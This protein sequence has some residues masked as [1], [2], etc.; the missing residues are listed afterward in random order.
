MEENRMTELSDKIFN[1]IKEHYLDG[2][3]RINGK[4][5]RFKIDGSKAKDLSRVITDKNFLKEIE[6]PEFFFL[7]DKDKAKLIEEVSDWV[8]D[9][10]RPKTPW[11][12]STK[13]DF[14]NLVPCID[15]E[16]EGDKFMLNKATGWVSPVTYKSWAVLVPKEVRE[17][18]NILRCLR[19]YQ[20]YSLDKS[21]KVEENEGYGTEHYII[22]TCIQPEWRYSDEQPEIAPIFVDFIE[23]L[24]TTKE[25]LQ[26]ALNWIYEA[27]YGRNATYLVMNGRKG[28][29]KNILAT[30]I[31][32][33]VGIHNYTE[34]PRSALT[35][36][37]N[38]YLIDKRL[39]LMDEI[40]F[41]EARE[42]D[43]LKSYLN[44]FQAVEGKGKDAKMIE[45][46]C[47]IILSSNT[48]KDVFIEP[49]DRRFSVMDLSETPLIESMGEAKIEE[50]A[51]YIESVEF[52]AAFNAYLSKYR[53]EGWNPNRPF[54]GA[55]FK[56][57]CLTSL[58]VWQASIYE[59]I[60][61]KE[62]SSY[63]VS[64]LMNDDTRRFFPKRHG[65]YRNFLE[66]F[67]VDGE[68]IGFY[69]RGTN[70]I[71]SEIIPHKRYEPEVIE[72]LE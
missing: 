3:S 27:V 25:S 39:V 46:H 38:T 52:P 35:K 67:T 32:K 16:S 45:L 71:D 12:L 51:E 54:I 70:I 2:I 21:V 4:R 48:D 56:R 10:L 29:G 65:D 37:F 23:S 68:V 11:T 64:D 60:I 55:T 6:A 43:K 22:N 28:I 7:E 41:R 72:D 69:E 63:K 40:S 30:A 8:H 34:A 33:L 59:A 53:V 61:S 47:S 15:L 44:T 26:Y 14:P 19:R 20:P 1:G 5:F 62:K 17:D 66:N 18:H 13:G 36:E 57:L 50:L 58:T 49:D 31:S 24:F 9:E 42:K